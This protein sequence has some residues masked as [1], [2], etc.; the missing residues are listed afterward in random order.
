MN[1]SKIIKEVQQNVANLLLTNIRID[2]PLANKIEDT[3]RTT[4]DKLLVEPSIT[5]CKKFELLFDF[6][7]TIPDD[8]KFIAMD[9]NRNWK[10]YTKRPDLF[11][12]VCS[13]EY[14]RDIDNT[15][16]PDFLNELDW[17]ESLIQLKQF[18]IPWHIAPAWVVAAS[19]DKDKIWNWLESS[20]VKQYEN[21]W[22]FNNSNCQF[23]YSE[24][25]ECKFT[26][27]WKKSLILK[28]II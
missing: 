19:M 20:D 7:H 1:K 26:P 28:P 16:I 8:I 23:Y 22:I 15:I 10:G 21:V 27:K 5:Q 25:F 3:I 9:I 17:K 18:R 6:V 13:E 11:D 4:L 2:I 12:M 24:P 14:Q